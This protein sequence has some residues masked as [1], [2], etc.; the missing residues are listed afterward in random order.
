MRT[1]RAATRGS[2]GRCLGRCIIGRL[3]STDALTDGLVTFDSLDP[4]SFPMT[5]ELVTATM[6][7]GAGPWVRRQN[8]ILLNARKPPK[9]SPPY[10]PLPRRPRAKGAGPGIGGDAGPKGVEKK[11]RPTVT[12]LSASFE[13][14]SGSITIVERDE[15]QHC[16][17][18]LGA[19]LRLA[20]PKHL[21]M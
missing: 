10:A 19:S 5:A 13:D 14:P 6:E 21:R 15:H 2:C 3:S 11:P 18:H 20:C 17:G 9:G 8:C 4:V 1:A 12:S 7:M 16:V